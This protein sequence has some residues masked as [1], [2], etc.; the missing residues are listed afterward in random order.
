VLRLFDI[1]PDSNIESFTG[2]EIDGQS[3]EV[4]G[5]LLNLVSNTTVTTAAA[6]YR[7]M[8]ALLPGALPGGTGTILASPVI[9]TSLQC[10]SELC[11]TSNL[12]LESPVVITITHTEHIMVCMY[13]YI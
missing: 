13:I 1:E 6:H 9:S 4:P 3:L 7:N 10:G 2:I 8:T 11:E 5:Q 12:V